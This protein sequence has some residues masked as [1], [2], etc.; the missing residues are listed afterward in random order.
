MIIAGILIIFLTSTCWLQVC[1]IILL[2]IG[3]VFF[4]YLVN[5]K[6]KILEF[7][8]TKFTMSKKSKQR[9]HTDLPQPKFSNLYE[10]DGVENKEEKVSP[11]KILTTGH[12]EAQVMDNIQVPL[13][14]QLVSKVYEGNICKCTFECNQPDAKIFCTINGE[15]VVLINR[16]LVLEENGTIC[17]YAEWNGTKSDE[18][19]IIVD[20]FKVQKPA[21]IVNNR[22]ICFQVG[23]NG[24]RVHYTLDGSTPSLNSN[25]YEGEFAINKS[26]TLK[27]VAVKENW[28]DSDVISQQINIIPTKEE[29]VRKFTNEPNV[30]GI[31][32]RGDSHIKSNSY[33]QDYHYFEKLNTHWNLAVVSDGAGSAKHSDEGSRAV[34][35][36]FSFYI[37]KMI[38]T[39]TR[40]NNG[41]ILDSKTWDIEFKGMLAR[42]QNELRKNLVR[43]DMP[44]ESFAATIII[45]LFSS[46][47][48][49]IAHVGDG[50]AGVK[51]NGEW[52]SIMSPHKGEE[53]NQTIFST[54]KYFG[55]KYMPNLKMSNVYVPETNSFQIPL[56]AFVLMSDG[57]ENGAWMTYQRINLPN[58]DFK[59][60]DVNKPRSNSLDNCLQILDL[61]IDY[62]QEAIIDYITESS[63]AFKNE[64]DDKTILIGKIYESI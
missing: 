43:D 42:F 61:P 7:I 17:V 4:L 14:V 39:D 31:S 56:E 26:C 46:K 30:I 24:S 49:M 13:N 10:G 33:C 48:F 54:S 57:C 35:A 59:V 18:L 62:R 2:T 16:L 29:R 58:G 9:N 60:E 51:V 41:D 19:C 3:G 12:Q 37:K 47:G 44:F 20:D 23:T 27:A 34:C 55:E 40:F 45:L 22:N 1:S 5:K 63:N 64:P 32:Y 15:K 21:V 11:P 6:F 50:R 36:A 53:A 28:K 52:R 25:L 38:E 8:K